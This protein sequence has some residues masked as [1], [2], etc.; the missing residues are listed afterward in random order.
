MPN[1]ELTPKANVSSFRKLALGTWRTV[2]DPSVYG[3]MEVRMD[4]ALQYLSAFRE[5][6]GKR[7]TV[8]HL[9]ARAM[10]EVLRQVPDANALLRWNRVY[11]RRRIGIFIQVAM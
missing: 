11:L 6:T 1:L 5:R 7:L 9:V 8:L 3:T 4:R 2:G 10:A